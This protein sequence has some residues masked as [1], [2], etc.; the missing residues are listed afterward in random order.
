[1]NTSFCFVSMFKKKGRKKAAEDPFIPP[2][3]NDPPTP[4]TR[5]PPTSRDTDSLPGK[6]VLLFHSQPGAIN[7]VM[8]PGS[9][10]GTALVI[11][12]DHHSGVHAHRAHVPPPPPPRLVAPPLL[13]IAMTRICV[14]CLAAQLFP[15]VDAG[16]KEPQR[17]LLT[18][19]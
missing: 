15:E 11:T 5:P 7:L 18:C 19:R 16:T 13:L 1:M 3:P 12:L 2:P 9:R 17:L 14:Q 4:F 8:P 6:S 10:P